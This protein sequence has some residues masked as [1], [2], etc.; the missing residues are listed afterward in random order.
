MLG[1]LIVSEQ[2]PLLFFLEGSWER[3]YKNMDL[4]VLTSFPGRSRLN[5]HDIVGGGRRVLIVWFPDFSCMGGARE[6]RER[7][8]W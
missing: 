8:V 1:D 2:T 7:R 3:D 6:G 5:T 4:L